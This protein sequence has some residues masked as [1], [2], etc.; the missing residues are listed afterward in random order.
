MRPDR[1]ALQTGPRR[2]AATHCPAS[3][4][5]CAATRSA[6]PARDEPG[7]VVLDITGKDEESVRAVAAEAASRRATPG[8]HRRS[9]VSPGNLG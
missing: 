9:G 2:P 1:R 7:L 4:A 3:A 5:N 8:V 6:R